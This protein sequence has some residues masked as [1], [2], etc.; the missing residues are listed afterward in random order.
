MVAGNLAGL[1]P[2]RRSG[3]EPVLNQSSEPDPPRSY[4]PGRTLMMPMS[5]SR[6]TGLSLAVALVDRAIDRRV[7]E[8][9]GL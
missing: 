2:D 4:N 3:S 6:L 8:A 1:Y 9:T 5:T 7:L